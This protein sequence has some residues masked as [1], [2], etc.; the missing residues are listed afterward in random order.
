MKNKKIFILLALVIA[1]TGCGKKS[2]ETNGGSQTA[3]N[4]IVKGDTAWTY[5]K[6]I[7]API[8]ATAGMESDT[9]IGDVERDKASVSLLRGS[10]DAD[11]EVSLV[12]PES[13]PEYIGS[14]VKMIGSP[15]E[16]KVSG[17]ETRLNEPVTVTFK[18]DPATID[19][20]RGTTSLRV[21]YYDGRHWEYIKPLA[22]DDKNNTISFITY[23]FSLFG[24]NQIKDDTVITENWIHSQ[25]LDK[26]MKSGLNKVSDKV[27][28]Q[29]IDMTLE[30]MGIS[31]KTLKGKILADVLK[32]DG[33]K[34]IYDAYQSDDK[35]DL[36]QKIAILAGKKIAENVSE[37]VFQE[38]LKN[39]TDG[40]TEDVAAV[41]KAAGYAAEGQYR[42]AAKIIGEQIADKFMLTT[43]GKIAVEVV[44]GQIQSWKNNEVEAA[45]TAYRDGSNAKFYGYNND[46]EDFDTVW[47][48]MRGVSRQLMLEAINKENAV[49]RESGMPSLTNKQMDRIRDSVKENYRKQFEA[50]FTKEEEL[51][52]EEEK[53]RWLM[54]AFKKNNL[55][56]TTTG[57]AGLDKGFDLETKLNLLNHFKEKMM[58]DTGRGD[59]TD[60]VGLLVDG[61]LSA[62]DVAQAARLWFTVPD[63]RK[64][65]ADFVKSRYNISLYPPLKDIAGKWNEGKFKIID[66]IVPP[67]YKEAIEAEKNKPKTG[68]ALEDGCDFNIDFTELKG[69]EAPAN[70]EISANGES[71]GTLKITGEQSL[72][73]PF[74]Y[75]GGVMSGS[76]VKDKA[77]MNLSANVGEEDK[78]YTLNGNINIVWGEIKIVASLI[79]T[80]DK[81]IV[82]PTKDAKE[83]PVTK[84][85]T[86]K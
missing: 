83:K 11:T 51:R 29:V 6:T 34:G 48:Q 27:A 46:K 78:T 73:F 53:L 8:I 40:G 14:E 25:T 36:S 71:D 60:K 49:R 23:H 67:G 35:I 77:T 26:Q 82:A 3:N 69:K 4:D 24:V 79:T 54:D 39:L 32:D 75:S 61:K 30:K 74:T 18:Y 5:E 50:R 10:F 63:G 72:D 1:L 28:E 66:V 80:K 52:K 68:N 15:L 2:S 84:P 12:T 37:S 81:A 22:I 56:D 85:N 13:V 86:K 70:V 44:N 42:E 65:Y 16:I 76:T 55:F 9:I 43:A 31:D 19:M 17:E 59:L 7:A 38:G 20:E 58:K 45:Y 47:S 33:Y 64:L 57:P 21:A 41:A 62:E